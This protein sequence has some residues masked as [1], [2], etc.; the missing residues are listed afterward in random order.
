MVLKDYLGCELGAKDIGDGLSLVLAE[1]ICWDGDCGIR[2]TN[3]C[4]IT[5]IRQHCLSVAFPSFY[6]A[7]LPVSLGFGILSLD[8]MIEE[9]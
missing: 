1:L 6:F 7:V 8:S 5:F 4:G 2:K 9:Q 3:I